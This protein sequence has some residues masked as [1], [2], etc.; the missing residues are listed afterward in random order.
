MPYVVQNPVHHETITRDLTRQLGNLTTD[1][2]EELTASFDEIW[3]TDRAEWRE[4]CPYST[5]QQIVARTSNRVFVGLP[6]CRD[7]ALLD[8]G[9]GFATAIP[10]SAIILRPIPALL[11]PLAALVIA[12]PNI[13]H[14]KSFTR[15]IRPEIERRLKRLQSQGGDVEK[16][17]GEA[18]PNDFLQWSI[19]RALESPDAAELAPE[20]ISGRLLAVNFAAIHTSTFTITNAVFDLVASD[21]SLE[22]IDQLRDEAASVLAND[23]GVWTKSGL[24]KMYK[25][26]STLRE[27]SRLGSFQGT[28][29][30]R[31]VISPAGITAP[32]GT[33][34]PYG[35]NI[36]VPTNSIHE[37][38][39]LYADPATF[40][41]FRFS[42]QRVPLDQAPTEK[43][44]EGMPSVDVPPATSAKGEEYI[45][46]ANLSFVSV[47][48]TYHPFG[49]GRHACPGRFFAANELKLLLAY[50]VLN[51]DFEMLDKRPESKC[52]GTNIVPPMTATIKIR[53]RG[54]A[55]ASE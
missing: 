8:H 42:S 24:A 36:S 35:T 43:D 11:R 47:S 31:K 3:G 49:Y 21:P 1:I 20:I 28:G 46:K 30:V 17:G 39:A 34:C 12:R 26:D 25:T 9:I 16:K 41:P 18:E 27:S 13:Y 5:L 29:L 32:N 51:Y 14:T 19:H 23:D 45:K 53:R 50:M 22:Y 52:V 2:M 44:K 38:P 37:D 33:F 4:V 10:L 7:R 54:T 48:P 55:S 6:A 40:Q 15:I